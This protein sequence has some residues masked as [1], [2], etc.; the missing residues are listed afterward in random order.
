M[1]LAPRLESPWVDSP[2]RSSRCYRWSRSEPPVPGLGRQADFW[3]MVRQGELDECWPWRTG[4]RGKFFW[5]VDGEVYSSLTHRLA[6]RL[7]YGR[8]PSPELVIAHRCDNPPCC[9]PFH[10]ECVAQA[11]N[12]TDAVV[13][14]LR[15]YD[16]E[17]YRSSRQ[18]AGRKSG[19]CR[20]ESNVQSKLTGSQVADIRAEY[21]A[22]ARQVD[23]AAKYQVGQS[24]I[25][26]VTR[27]TSWRHV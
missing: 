22:G 10:L 24:T 4:K 1:R 2:T 19:R 15:T 9:N 26:R 6:W 17:T 23:L 14:G 18:E 27:G 13:R 20:G 12:V 8:D 11:R 25:S 5:R 21:L 7:T 3:C 16:G